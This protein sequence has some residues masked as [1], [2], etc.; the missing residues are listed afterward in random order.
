VKKAGLTP[1]PRAG[2]HETGE[3]SDLRSFIHLLREAGE[4]AEIRREVSAVHELGAVLKACELIGKA[5]YFD[6]VEGYGAPVIGGVLGSHGRISLALGAETQ[7]DVFERVRAA[8]MNPIA[9]EMVQEPAP[10]QEVVIDASDVDLHALP[11]PTHAP[12]DVAPFINA[13]IVIAREP[14]TGRHNLSFNRLQIFDRNVTGINMNAW[15]DMDEFLRQAEDQGRNLPFCVAIGVDP[16]LQMS[17]AFRYPG[18]EYEIAGALRK[19]PVPVTPAGTCDV[20]VPAYAEYILEGEVLAGERRSEG[21]MAEFTGHYSGTTDQ[22]VARIARITHR[23][24]PIFQTIAGA[25]AEHLLLGNALTREP[26]LDTAV[27]NMSPRVRAVRLPGTGFAAV[28]TMEDPRPGEPRSVAL[29]ALSFHV[30]TKMVIVVDADVNIDDPWDLLWAISTRVRWERDCVIIPGALGN[31]LDPSS[32][33]NSVQSKVI[34]DAV[35]PSDTDRTY[36]KVR[37][38]DIDLREYLSEQ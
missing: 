13:G 27:R 14:T 3:I 15:R 8:P 17:A 16:V 5:A 28:I 33:R 11:V 7:S 24:D 10:C 12:D 22:P 30:N 1:V 37:Y 20:L 26:A 9:P 23:T 2:A 6:R 18:D 25:S 4:I 19:A 32:D 35:L 38:P 29:A 21:P 36:H 34:I 31:P